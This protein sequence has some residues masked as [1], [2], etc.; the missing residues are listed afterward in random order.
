M[1]QNIFNPFNKPYNTIQIEDLELLKDVCEG[2]NVEYKRETPK[3]S[4]IA[5]SIA[6]F[7]NSHG[8]I[9]IIGVET[10]KETNKVIDIIGVDDLPDKIHDSVRGNLNP[11]PVFETYSVILNTAKKVI[12]VVVAK[13]Q[14]TPY[15]H[16][17][18]RIYRRQESSSDPIFESN[19]YSIDELYKRKE[20]LEKE[21]ESFRNIDYGFCEG[22]DD[23]PFLSVF[24]NT[25]PFNSFQIEDFFKKDKLNALMSFF[26]TP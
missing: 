25:Y 8:G 23:Y 9:Y 19:R 22:E 13:G 10:S 18:G 21:K 5:K 7:A 26:N 12:I 2:W 4:K 20:I 14:D 6:S 24:I 11:F 16:N 17:D 1:I 3:P 15:I